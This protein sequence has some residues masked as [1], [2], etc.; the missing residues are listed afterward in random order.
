M[1]DSKE[2]MVAQADPG[3]E[4]TP[5]YGWIAFGL[6]LATGSTIALEIVLTRIFS[7]ILWYHYGFMSISLALF[8][9]GLAG[10]YVYL[11][12]GRFSRAAAGRVTAQAALLFALT[13]MAALFCFQWVVSVPEHWPLQMGFRTLLFVSTAIPFFFAGLI[14][15]VPLSR[16]TERIGVLYG[17]DL[18]GAAVGA[19]LVIPLL[20]W[21]GGH[22]AFFACSAL[23]ALAGITF[24]IAERK[25]G[26]L[27]GGLVMLGLAVA[28]IGMTSNTDYFRIR[29]VKRGRSQD[30]VIAERWNSFSRVAVAETRK[31]EPYRRITIDG[32][33][34]TPML[35]FSGDLQSVNFLARN[36]QALAYYIHPHKRALI[37][38]SGG[39]PDILTAKLFEVP[40]I[41]AV[42]INPL[43]VDYVR[44][45]FRDY[46][47]SPYDLP[48]VSFTVAD[49]RSFVARS[50]ETYDLIQLSEVDTT[51]AQAAGALTLVENSL[52]TVEA[53]QSYYDHLTENGILSVTRNWTVSSQTMALRTVD[54]IRRSWE[55]RGN[56]DLARSLIVVA[57][58][59][60]TA[61]SWGTLLASR[62][63]FTA[64]ELA[65]V[66]RVAKRLGW[67]VLYS[68]VG[69]NLESINAL[70]GP[71]RDEFLRE[72]PYDV[73]ATTDDRPYF[74]FFL[75]PLSFLFGEGDSGDDLDWGSRRTPRILLQLFVLISVLV[76][77]FTFLL[78][79]MIGRLRFGALHGAGRGLM[80]FASIGLGFILVELSFIQRYTLLLGQPLYAFACILGCIL[81]C[82][83]CGSFVTHRMRDERRAARIALSILIGGV[84]IHAFLIP[85]ILALSMG[86]SLAARIG[87]TVATIAPLGFLMGMPLPLGM[88]LLKRESPQAL[89]WAWGVNG[90]LSVFGTVLAMVISIFLG[91]TTTIL[92]GALGYL[93][94]LAAVY[95]RVKTT[96]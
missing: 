4:A 5:R 85:W 65:S 57:P 54:L 73:S 31:P 37:I 75:R 86:F 81:V 77:V 62:R 59:P 52:Y 35:P 17:A 33:A 92:A 51:A 24:S 29:Y 38:G 80:Y 20:G 48:G 82:S 1:E 95:R 90:S 30:D 58:G 42:E 87:V 36:I 39:G 19:V 63:P 91:I 67:K 76:L 18:L 46:T 64:V 44:N 9:I 61:L 23:A 83:G 25:K 8:G 7:V 22:G 72:F 68:P 88:R 50:D 84:T 32:G 11:F 96:P 16:Y 27:I 6:A 12:P 47:G 93:G 2:E 71:G 94:A 49:G 53:F 55:S 10:V 3:G 28:G 41:H 21:L 34:A 56:T 45:V 70:L 60:E 14:V 78:P 89:A 13:S 79:M 15:A 43:I 69:K 40:S 66:N 74:F 26:L